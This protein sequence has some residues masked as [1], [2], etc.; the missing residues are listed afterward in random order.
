MALDLYLGGIRSFLLLFYYHLRETIKFLSRFLPGVSSKPLPTSAITGLFTYKKLWW[1]LPGTQFENCQ[2]WSVGW[3]A[4]LLRLQTVKSAI[5]KVNSSSLYSPP[6]CVTLISNESSS[7]HQRA[8]ELNIELIW[9]N[10]VLPGCLFTMFALHPLHTYLELIRVESRTF[11]MP[12][13]FSTLQI[14]DST[15]L[16]SQGWQG[17]SSA[18][19]VLPLPFLS[20]WDLG[21][22]CGSVADLWQL[23]TV[24]FLLIK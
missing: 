11:W 24:F 13:T 12:S 17:A 16:R 10:L 9:N 19:L 14:Y 18:N 4:S 8:S 23:Y 1:S 15:S 5:H 2:D 3:I 20:N 6:M 21:R 7:P 22:N